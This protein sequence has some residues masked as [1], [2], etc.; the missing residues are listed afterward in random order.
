MEILSRLYIEACL[1]LTVVILLNSYISGS[2]EGVRSNRL[3]HHTRMIKGI[4]TIV[5]SSCLCYLFQEEFW[6]LF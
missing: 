4:H 6:F 5:S 2:R 1:S 3:S